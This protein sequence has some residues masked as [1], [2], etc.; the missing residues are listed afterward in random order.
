MHALGN[1]REIPPK[2]NRIEILPIEWYGQIHCASSALKR[3]LLGT[4]LRTVPK[5]R[6]IANDVVF[7][8]L[9]YMTPDF[10]EEV[11]RC[12]TG[13]INDFYEKFLRI[14]PGFIEGGGKCSLMGHSL[15]SVIVWDLLSILQQRSEKDRPEMPKD[16]GRCEIDRGSMIPFND[17][18]FPLIPT[19]TDPVDQHQPMGYQA[20][21]AE[22][23]ESHAAETG[24]WGPVL[25]RPMDQTI[26][27][28]PDFTIF[29]G[30]PL[31]LFLSLRGAHPVFD[32][33]RERSNAARRG[34]SAKKKKEAR[35]E[36]WGAAA[37]AVGGD[38]GG[39]VGEEDDHIGVAADFWTAV[40]K[41]DDEDV[42]E[43][44]FRLPTGAC[45]NVFHPSDPIAYRIEPLLLPC[46]TLDGDLPPPAF[47]TVGEKGL[48][49]HV[50]ARELG[51]TLVRSMRIFG[52]GGLEEAVAA[53]TKLAGVDEVDRG[54]QTASQ[55][56]KKGNLKFELGGRSDRV[57][58]S[59]QPGIVDNEYLSAIT[60]HGCYLQN[61][62]VLDFVIEKAGG[63]LRKASDSRVMGR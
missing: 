29:L 44:P 42:V 53:V 56:I 38:G 41:G 57:D 48:R 9:M 61:E 6:S 17:F 25:R 30:S 45:Y 22:R 49:L 39:V 24:T 60:A 4:T 2:P 20:Y 8:V 5:L 7:D 40:N 37:A 11:L 13:Q 31:G 27:F 10:C 32:E 1:K 18:G 58:F 12:V 34:E 15:G 19:A 59:L 3:T 36:M 16:D 62:D 23:G 35:S 43:C 33:M 50:K 14:F 51:D 63:A 47:V 52:G 26:P 55:R 54:G 28:L 21:C 46:T